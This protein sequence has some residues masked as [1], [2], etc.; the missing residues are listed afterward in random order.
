[1]IKTSE[2]SRLLAVGAHNIYSVVR[3]ATR[4]RVTSAAALP[5][6]GV[7]MYAQLRTFIQPDEV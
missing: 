3:A 6:A 2:I 4:H 5:E 1:M 7:F